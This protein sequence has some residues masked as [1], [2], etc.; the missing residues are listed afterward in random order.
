MELVL[1]NVSKTLR[2]TQVIDGVT[3][4][5]TGGRVYGLRGYNGSGKTMLMR[6]MAGLLRPTAGTVAIDGKTLGRDIDF[7]SSLGL[8]LESPAFLPHYTGQ[9]NLRLIARLR[10]AAGEEQI[11]AALRRVGLDPDDRRKYR[12]YSL[13]MK[14]RLGIACAIFESPDILLLDEPTN[15]LDTAGAAL[16]RD[17]I[18][19]ERA[20][21]AL[22][23]VASHD[24]EQLDALADVIYTI[25]HGQI[26]GEETTP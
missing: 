9:E 10:G 4:R 11:R 18:R 26:V 8:F 5:L 17:I 15:A 1:D 21:G 2:R 19:D 7:P 12:K 6:L 14:Q 13:G 25:E 20:R 24:R 23:V 22:V 3:L 16:V